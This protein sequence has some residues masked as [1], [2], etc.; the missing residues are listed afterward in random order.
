MNILDSLYYYA[1]LNSAAKLSAR[2]AVIASEDVAYKEALAVLKNRRASIS[3]HDR[4][5]HPVPVRAMVNRLL[6][7][8]KH[9]SATLEYTEKLITENLCMFDASGR[10]YLFNQKRF[11]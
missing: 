5:N 1:D 3:V 8:R 2:T 10:L 7:L 4:I 6:S 11:F 9:Q